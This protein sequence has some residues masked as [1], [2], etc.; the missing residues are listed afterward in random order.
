MLKHFRYTNWIRLLKGKNILPKSPPPLNWN[1]LK[2]EGRNIFISLP[3]DSRHIHV[4]NHMLSRILSGNSSLNISVLVPPAFKDFIGGM[5]FYTNQYV[6]P[7]VKPFAFP[8]T[9]EMISGSIRETWD[10]GIDLNITPYI[11][12]HYLIA[13]RSEKA[14][15]GFHN[16]F[17]SPLFSMTLKL[18]ESGSYDRGFESLLALAGID[19]PD[20]KSL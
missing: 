8:I 10:L 9:E 15:L 1:A 4:V 14:S 7:P 11:I 18:S 17:T 5:R 12:S 20:Q 3:D 2:Q 13:T 16:P 6:L 19:I